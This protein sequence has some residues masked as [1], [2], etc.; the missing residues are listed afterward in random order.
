LH[1][2]NLNEDR[3]IVVPSPSIITEIEVALAEV[4]AVTSNSTLAD[5]A[6]AKLEKIRRAAQW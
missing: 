4:R 6:F 5:L 1:N 3:L 2:Q